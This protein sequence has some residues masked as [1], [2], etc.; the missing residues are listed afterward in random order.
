MDYCVVFADIL[1]KRFNKLRAL[2]P[3]DEK[4]TAEETY[5]LR[6]LERLHMEVTE[7]LGK[8]SE[9]RPKPKKNH[10]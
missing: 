2:H 1:K 8:I 4:L 3:D 6:Q 9:A 7:Y 10:V 5:L